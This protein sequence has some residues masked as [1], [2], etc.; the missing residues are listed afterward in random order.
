MEENMYKYWAATLQDG[1]F[2]TLRN[3]IEQ[4]GSEQNLYE[5]SAHALKEKL[6]LGDRL[7]K[8]ITSKR[9]DYEVM[10][11]YEYMKESNIRLVTIHDNEY[12][13]KLKS[14]KDAP[15]ALFVKGKL[16]DN[17][18][19]AVAIIG[20]R[21]CSEYGR[22][23]AEYFGDRL[24]REHV[25]IISGMAWGIDGISQMAAL[26]ALGNTYAIL[27][28]GVDEIYPK[29]N[30]ELYCRLEENSECGII[31]EYAPKTKAIAR[32]FPP[33]NRLISAF[34]DVLLVVEARAKSGTLI[35]VEMAM[36]QAKEIMIVPGRIT[37]PLSIGCLRL[38]R[39]GA[40]PALSIED[41]LSKLS[42]VRENRLPD[43]CEDDD[44]PYTGKLPKS[45]LQKESL[46]KEN[47]R[48]ERLQNG[49]LQTDK[50]YS[51][52]D[53]ASC[54][55]NYTEKEILSILDYYP[56]S[57]ES[58][59]QKSKLG[60]GD[61]MINLTTL[62]MKGLIKEVSPGMFVLCKPIV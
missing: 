8:H 2:A 38:M 23:M 13:I 4:A 52:Y 44:S 22:L 50:S 25:N 11:G 43:I 30:R 20:A 12:P 19:P 48:K 16:P 32:L 33:R 5:M 41:V 17:N 45:N 29:S 47:L 7:I 58:I 46:R 36:Q 51:D 55:L 49:K 28:C 57:I 37:D 31:S 54:E 62:E 18:A 59:S 39:D 34:C 1:Y 24:A 35:T 6:S 9:N 60:A 14:L 27:G 26:D 40:E 15:Y 53:K 42:L 21:E 10:S 3:V 61:I 56:A